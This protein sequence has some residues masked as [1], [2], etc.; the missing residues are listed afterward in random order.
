LNAVANAQALEPSAVDPDRVTICGLSDG[1]FMALQFAVAHRG[2]GV[3]AGGPYTCARLD[4]VR[5]FGVC[6]RRHPD[7][8]DSVGAVNAAVSP[9]AIDPPSNLERIRGWR[10]VGATCMLHCTDAVRAGADYAVRSG[11]QIQAIA[12]M[13]ERLEQPIGR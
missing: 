4:P 8:H 9:G 10:K 6:L 7:W 2:V 12:A 3:I 13:I 1:G 5:V 11:V